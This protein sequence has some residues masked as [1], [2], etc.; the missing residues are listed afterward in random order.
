MACLLGFSSTLSTTALIG[1]LRYNPTTSAALGANSLVGAHTPTAPP[2]HIDPCATQNTPDGVN[3]GVEFLRHRRPIPVGHAGRRFLLQQGQH[4]V[5]KR[6]VIFDRLARPQPVTQ[7]SQPPQGEA[8][9]PLETE[10][11]ETLSSRAT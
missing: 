2:L 9:A 6:G 3:A 10:G 8:L 11:M 5:A 4:P 7:S 1:G